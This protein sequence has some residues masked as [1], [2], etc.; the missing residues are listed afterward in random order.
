MQLKC[1]TVY[2]F[3]ATKQISKTKQNENLVKMLLWA[4]ADVNATDSVS[5]FI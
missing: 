2:I 1:L 3:T 5:G 4:G